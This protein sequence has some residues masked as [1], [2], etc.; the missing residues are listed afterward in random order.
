MVDPDP[1][2][3]T[4]Y[5]LRALSWSEDIC[6]VAFD[7]GA[8]I[9]GDQRFWMKALESA[10]QLEQLTREAGVTHGNTD[11][12]LGKGGFRIAIHRQRHRFFALA[13]PARSTFVRSVRRNMRTLLSSLCQ[14]YPR[15][16]RIDNGRGSDVPVDVLSVRDV[17]SSKV[18][19]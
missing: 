17:A 14:E 8:H 13:F 3:L 19:L 16:R 4:G 15:P 1:S 7:E 9:R 12:Y 6:L 5:I 2:F 10:R 18:T 11:I